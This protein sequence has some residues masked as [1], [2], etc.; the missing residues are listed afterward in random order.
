MMDE[1]TLDN[2]A[3]SAR[4]VGS[5]ERDVKRL[6]REGGRGDLE[7]A[8]EALESAIHALDPGLS[9]DEIAQLG[10]RVERLAN[11]CNAIQRM[12]EAQ[13]RLDAARERHSDL[14]RKARASR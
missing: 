12:G 8:Q 4:V 5:L 9:L 7:E 2:I 6:K 3:E 1:R 13:K 10:G 14:M 11:K